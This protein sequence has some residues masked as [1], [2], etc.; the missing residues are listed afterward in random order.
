MSNILEYSQTFQSELDKQ[1]IAG[2][3]SGWMELN[4]DLVKYSGGNEVKIPKIILDGLADYDRNSGFVEGSLNLIWETKELSQDR[5]RTFSIDNQDSDESG[6][7][8]LAGAVLGEFQRTKVIPEVDA[9]RYSYIATKAINTNKVTNTYVASKTDIIH[10]LLTDVYYI[11]DIVGEEEP[12]VITMSMAVSPI[13]DEADGIEKYLDVTD[14]KQG[15]IS[16]KT[17]SINGCPI[18]RVPRLRMKTSYIFND[19]TTMGQSSGGFAEA[20]GAKDINWII[21]SRKSAIAV[22]KT[23]E[24]RIFEPDVNQ[25]ADAW[26]IDYRKLYDLWIP[27]NKIDSIWVNLKQ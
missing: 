21:T 27:D 25:K 22:S 10:R 17:K 11:L 9:Y 4:A 8:N 12:L 5:G 15:E 2:A 3:T 26:K 20:N 19:G 18:I 23:D 1:M 13:L 6:F 7:A 16:F 14:F 24:I